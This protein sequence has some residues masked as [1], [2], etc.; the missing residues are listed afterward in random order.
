V[1]AGEVA[2]LDLLGLVILVGVD[3]EDVGLVLLG[4][5]LR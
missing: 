3:L 4:L 2:K 1:R 5:G